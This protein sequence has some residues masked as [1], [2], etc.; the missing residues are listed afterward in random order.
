MKVRMGT[1][2]GN[3]PK[4]ALASHMANLLA[5]RA[6]SLNKEKEFRHALL[7]YK[8]LAILFLN[9]NKKF[10][11]AFGEEDW[12]GAF[13]EFQ[14]KRHELLMQDVVFKFTDGS[15][16]SISLSDLANLKI[17]SDHDAHH[18]KNVL[19]EQAVNLVQ[20]AQ[21]E[22][23]WNQIKSFASLKNIQDNDTMYEQE[24]HGVPK[25]IIRWRYPEDNEAGD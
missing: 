13:F 5:T 22:L 4:E 11:F 7:K 15:V 21:E 25:K 24:W 3:M 2:T 16:W 18:D 10:V 8:E 19:L 20:W 23:S 14:Q 1:K 9:E 12:V 6:I 17:L